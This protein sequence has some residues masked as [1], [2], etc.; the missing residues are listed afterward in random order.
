MATPAVSV[1]VP[2]HDA[3]D[4]IRAAIESIIAQTVRDF[5]I[6]VVDDGSRD[7]TAAVVESMRH[8]NPI[9][10]IRTPN[11][12]P[13]AARNTGARASEAKYVAFLDSDDLWLPGYLETMLATLDGA[14][15]LAFTDAW[16][17][18][19]A[20]GKVRRATA[21]AGQRPPAALPLDSGRLFDL[22]VER[23]F[24]YTSVTI[25]REVLLRCGGYDERLWMAEDYELWLRLATAGCSMLRAPGILAVHRSR[26]GSLTSDLVR[27]VAG[28]CDVY[29]IVASEYDLSEEQR[30]HVLRQERR[31]RRRLARV[32][33]DGRT[34]HDALG[35]VRRALKRAGPSPWL[36]SVPP[37]VREAIDRAAPTQPQ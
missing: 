11:A 17:L 26:S 37:D 4:T 34:L 36:Q 25:D 33:S 31:W 28:R 6:V 15:A 24:V 23:N 5:E 21:M 8:G 3:G 16:V 35:R 13:S 30:E 20:T 22:L 32:E 29:R 18:D 14:A 7:E 9:R 10:L 27:L 1:V 12:G 19:E 2:A